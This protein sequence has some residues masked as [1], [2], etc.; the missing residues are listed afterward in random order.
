MSASDLVKHVVIIVKENHTFDNYFGRFPGVNG[1]QFP[2]A[3]DPTPDPPHDHR[4]WLKRNGPTGAVRLQYTQRDIPLYW[5]FAR[6]YT[7]CDNYFTDVAS[8]SEPNHLMLIAADSPIIDN[9]SPHRAYQ[10]QPPYDLPSLPA[11][12]GAGGHDWRNYADQ[13]ASYFH[14]IANLVDHP[15][16]VPSDQ[17]DR[18]VGNGYLPAVCWLYAPEGQSEHPPR[19]PGA[20]PVVGPGMQW[21]VDRVSKVGNSPLWGS[22]V[23]FITWDDWGGWHDHVDPPNDSS[24]AGGGPKDYTGSQFRYGPRVPCLVVSP[25]ARSGYI[26]KVRHS[27]VS[28]VKFCCAQFGVPLWNDRLKS[29]DDMLDCFDFSRQPASAPSA[30]PFQ[31]E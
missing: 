16:N 11:A 5:A 25:Y 30:I 19:N 13:N 24:W 14:H 3:G 28:L 10:P 27:H 15:S 1:A 31:N 4:A 7:L 29:A 21:T 8:Q 6:K 2:Q 26:S 17:F 20:G 18:D 12:L 22:T 9:A 23:I